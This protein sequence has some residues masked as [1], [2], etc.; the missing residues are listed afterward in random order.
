MK[1]IISFLAGCLTAF[2]IVYGAIQLCLYF[3]SLVPPGDAA[4]LMKLVIVI[5]CVFFGGGLTL[6]LTVMAA[7]F[8]GLMLRA[9]LGK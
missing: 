5:A 7:A 9:V 8:V 3:C 1:N 2:G 4:F 6:W